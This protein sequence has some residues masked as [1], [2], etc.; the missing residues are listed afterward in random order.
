MKAVYVDK[1]GGIDQLRFGEFKDPL[2]ANDELLARIH[3]TALNRADLLQREGRYPPP[4]GTAPILGLEFAGTVERVGEHCSGWRAG[5]RVCGLLPG[6]GYAQ[7]VCIPAKMAI[8]MPDNLSFEEAAAIPEVFLTAYL[9]LCR[10][11]RMRSGERVLIHAGASGVGSAAIQLAKLYG[12]IAYVT[13]GSAKKLDFC[14]QLGAQIAINYRDG[15]FASHILS[16]TENQGVDLILDCVGAPYWS[17]NIQALANDG[18]LVIIALMGGAK[19]DHLSL[20]PVLQKRLQII[21][22][23]LRSRSPEFKAELT[24]DF[25]RDLLPA[26]SDGRL[27]PV[28]DSIFDWEEV[29]V[30]HLRMEQNLNMGKIVMRVSQQ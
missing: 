25:V 5:D 27:K 7:M 30:A 8:P 28:I 2:P 18:R 4:A 19:I 22:S 17:E 21:G 20:L 11:G 6:G 10:L 13:A 24:Q 29:R 3:A 26:F 23:T 15:K 12:A 1:P 9:T 16:A 14:L